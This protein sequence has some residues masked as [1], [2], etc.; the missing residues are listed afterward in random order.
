MA[1]QVFSGKTTV[2]TAGTH[3]ALGTAKVNGPVMVKA[4]I[5]AKPHRSTPQIC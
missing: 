5:L 4:L 3:V 1:G 2:T